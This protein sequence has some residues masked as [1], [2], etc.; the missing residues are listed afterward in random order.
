MSRNLIYKNRSAEEFPAIP[1]T[2]LTASL[3]VR[4]LSCYRIRFLFPILCQS[5][6]LFLVLSCYNY[7]HFAIDFKFMA[8][9]I[10]H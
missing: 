4:H 10:L 6:L 8:A 7:F 9:K 3:Q 5:S 2:F 1:V